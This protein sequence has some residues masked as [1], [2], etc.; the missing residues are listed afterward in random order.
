MRPL[1]SI[2]QWIHIY[3]ILK[4]L[5]FIVTDVISRR[6]IFFVLVLICVKHVMDMSSGPV[7]WKQCWTGVHR[8][9]YQAPQLMFFIKL[10]YLELIEH[11]Y[12]DWAID[13][14]DGEYDR[15][16]ISMNVLWL[17]QKAIEQFN[18]RRKNRWKTNEKIWIHAFIAITLNICNVERW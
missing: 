4:I 18:N 13:R 17:W 2:Q 15:N 6:A 16:F 5:L 10:L 8:K 7:N 14:I 9:R 3:L 12:F 1:I 11:F